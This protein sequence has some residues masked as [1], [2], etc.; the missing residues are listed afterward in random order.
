MIRLAGLLLVALASAVPA[1]AGTASRPSLAL[2]ASP[3]HV[4]L[5]GSARATV[6]VSNTGAGRVVIDAAR[7]GFGLD[8][9]G[10]PRII[11]GGRSRDA[12]AWLIVRPRRL[13]IRPGGSAHVAVSARLPRDARPGD[14]EAVVLLTTRPRRQGSVAVRTRLGVVVDVRAPGEIVRRLVLGRLRLVRD[15]RLRTLELLLTN[16]GNVVE[17]IARHRVS[18]VLTQRGRVVARLH[19]DPRELL[20]QTKGLVLFHY[21][22]R[23]R[24]RVA[25]LA[26]VAPEAGTSTLYRTYRLRL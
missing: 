24:G 13:A 2:T 3:A 10:R 23:A 18:L 25:A 15:G 5:E 21:G 20:P 12:C 6:R 1:S 19:P 9:R 7:A 8:L 26:T 16:R 11:S 22:G 4:T 14:H 17:T